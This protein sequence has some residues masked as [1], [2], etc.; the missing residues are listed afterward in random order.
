MLKRRVSETKLDTYAP[1]IRPADL[2][3][4]LAESFDNTAP[5]PAEQPETQLPL[6]VSR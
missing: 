1:R 5:A 3:A 2:F 4:S 6:S